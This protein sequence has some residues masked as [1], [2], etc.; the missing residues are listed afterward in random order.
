MRDIALGDHLEDRVGAAVEVFQVVGAELV[1]QDR[2]VVVDRLE[3]AEPKTKALAATLSDLGFEK[4]LI[5]TAEPGE[6][7]FLASRNLP[8]VYAVDVAGIDPVSLVSADK[9]VMTV[10]AVEKIQEWLG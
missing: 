7:L 1:R 8:G 3:L 4:G 5:V 9:V 2:L 10:D 6:N